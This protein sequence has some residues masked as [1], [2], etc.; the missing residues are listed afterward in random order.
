VQLGKV[1]TERRIVELVGNP[2]QDLPRDPRAIAVDVEEAEYAL[3]LLEGLDQSVQQN[4]I[5]ASIVE[6][7]AILVLFEKGVH[8]NL[9]CGE[10]WSILP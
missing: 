10:T 2:G 1:I 3:G 5:E 9:Q 7:D 6:L 8:G 4:P